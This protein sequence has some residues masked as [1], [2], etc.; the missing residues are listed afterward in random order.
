MKLITTT[1]LSLI[2]SFSAIAQNESPYKTSLKA[3]G[4]I[5]LG[6]LG[7][8]YLG[9]NMIK[10]KDGLTAA[11]AA[12]KTP[13]DVNGFDRFSAGDFSDRADKDSYIPFYASFA[14]PVVMLLNK[15]ESKKAGQIMVLFTESMAITG[16]MF[17]LTA[18][19]VQRSRPFVYGTE[20]PLAKRMDKDSQ[21]AFYAGHTAATA[22]AT[23]FLAK[24][25]QD[26]NPDSK[27]KPYV[28]A[29]AALVPASVGYLRL[30]AGQHF[31]SD[32]LLGYALGAGVGILVPQLHKKG[33]T[34][35][36]SLSPSVNPDYKG[37]TLLYSLK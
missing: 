3:D 19:S 2:I 5:I 21:R 37:A 33:S 25:F 8:G 4:P 34:S 7:L 23:F 36:F 20:A 28:W 24:V 6:S 14:A 17:S 31:L 30:R 10:N 32:N 15:N 12:M 27:A 18:G 22:T 16:A 1:L 9:L 26:F 11:E 35:N 13:D 29:A